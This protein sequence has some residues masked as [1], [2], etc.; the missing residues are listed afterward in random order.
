MFLAFFLQ[1]YIE[2]ETSEQGICVGSINCMGLVAF[3]CV[4]RR[5]QMMRRWGRTTIGAT[6]TSHWIANNSFTNLPPLSVY[7]NDVGT[8]DWSRAIVVVLIL[9]SLPAHA[10]PSTIAKQTA[11]PHEPNTRQGRSNRE[12][13]HPLFGEL[14]CVFEV[15]V[16]SKTLSRQSAADGL[17]LLCRF[18]LFAHSKL[19]QS[20]GV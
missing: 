13:L 10:H 16:W 6:H 15:R 9:S 8:V 2:G 1:Q 17:R 7:R 4:M 20:R 3:G 11:A 18:F 19:E 5:P 12:R 14:M